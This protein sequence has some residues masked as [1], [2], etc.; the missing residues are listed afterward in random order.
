M[1][2]SVSHT[3][4]HIL[5]NQMQFTAKQFKADKGTFNMADE[6]RK[7]E[8]DEIYKDKVLVFFYVWM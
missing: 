8:P 6:M 2:M 3:V 5:E 1:E 4:I 7:D